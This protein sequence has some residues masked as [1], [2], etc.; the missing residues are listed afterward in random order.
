MRAT[1]VVVLHVSLELAPQ[2]AHV[3]EGHATGEFCL[4][5]VEKDS[6]CA[7]SSGPWGGGTLEQ[8]ERCGARV[9]WRRH[10]LRATV[11]MKVHTTCPAPRAAV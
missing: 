7:L 4:Q 9:E 6:M 3:V 10:V 8:S 2:S 11:A 5:R 1:A